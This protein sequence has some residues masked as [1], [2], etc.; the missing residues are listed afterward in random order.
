MNFK[1]YFTEAKDISNMCEIEDITHEDMYGED[2]VK[3]WKLTRHFNIWQEVIYFIS[4][5]KDGHY[6]MY[7]EEG[8]DLL[9]ARFEEDSYIDAI[10]KFEFKNNLT[11]Q[12]KETFGD[13]IDEL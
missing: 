9:P 4:L 1:Q 3:S 12:T 11:P 13:I 7:D 2:I 5:D 10:K 6:Q 8:N